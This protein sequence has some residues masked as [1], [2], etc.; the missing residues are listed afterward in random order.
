MPVNDIIEFIAYVIPGFLSLQVFRSFYPVK[1]KSDFYQI[2]WSIIYGVLITSFIKLV[3]GKYLNNILEANK[4]QFPSFSFI[5]CLVAVGT[6][7]GL[8]FVGFYKL[9]FSLAIKFEYLKWILPNPQ[10]IWIEINQVNNLNWA[11]IFLNDGAIYLG[12]IKKYRFDPNLENQDFLLT[13]A[14][15][16]DEKLKEKY[17][18]DGEGVYL[19]TR[20]VKRIEFV[21]GV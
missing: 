15:R 2:S 17:S 8:L 13:N 14:K 5:I 18:I 10:S 6:L 21:R 3:D 9:R 12:W 7:L 11:V 4:E 20:D 19:N 1:R 16:V